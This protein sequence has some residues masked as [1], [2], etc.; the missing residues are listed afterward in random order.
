M[1]FVLSCSTTPKRINYLIQLLS[2]MKLR[3]KYFVINICSRYKRFGEFKIPKELLKLCKMNNKIIFQFVDDYG[4][5]CKYIGGFK[6][7]EKKKL[8]NDK[9]IIVD[10]D[11]FYHNNLFYGLMDDKTDSNITTGSGFDYDNNRN[12]KITTGQVE[13]VEGYGGV[14]FNYNQ[15]SNIIIHYSKYYKCINSFK[16]DDLVEKYLC[17]SFLGDDFIISQMYKDKYAI[18]DGRKL[19][20]PCSYGFEEDALH[21]NNSFGSNMG[22]YLF[23]YENIK[24]LETFVNKYELNKEIISLS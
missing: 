18:K 21:K 17:A 13:M 6:F 11:T 22:S 24:I 2:Q 1:G 15:I 7:L 12:Y 8:Y 23:L 16:S 9:L 5:L 14:C 20:N 19:L 10:D 3:Y 4:P